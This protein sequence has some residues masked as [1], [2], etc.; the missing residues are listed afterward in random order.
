MP[1]PYRHLALSVR[2]QLLAFEAELAHLPRSLISA[3]WDAFDTISAMTWKPGDDVNLE[4]RG[5]MKA[6][7]WEVS[8]TSY[9][10]EREVYAWRHNVRGGPSPT[11]R[12]ARQVLEDCPAFVVVYHLDQL[13]VAQAMRRHPDARLVVVQSGSNVT[14]ALLDEV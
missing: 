10:A 12:I 1:D 7:G 14:T 4:V 9:D 13:K 3:V 2:L 8:R 6:K 11:L 5:W